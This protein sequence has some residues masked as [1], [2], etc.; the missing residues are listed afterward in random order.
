MAVVLSFLALQDKYNTC[1]LS[2]NIKCICSHQRLDFLPVC[3]C[4]FSLA[5][6][7]QMIYLSYDVM[8]VSSPVYHELESRSGQTKDY[9]NDICWFSTKHTTVRSKSND[10]LS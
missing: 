9:K 10:W 6:L 5:M 8:V 3:V 1:T 4:F 7:F 2:E